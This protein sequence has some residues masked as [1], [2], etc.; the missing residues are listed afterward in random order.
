M[1]RL[2]KDFKVSHLLIAIN[3]ALFSIMFITDFTL[4][5]Y[6]LVLFGAK[7]NPLIEAG[8][9]YRLLTAAFVHADLQ[10]LLF[11]CFALYFIGPVVE[12]LFGKWRFLP[13]YLASAIMGT[14]MSYA[15]SDSLSV[16]ASGAIFGLL[17]SH[18]YLFLR[19]PSTY[20]KVYGKDFLIMIGLNLLLG[21]SV[22]NIDNFGHLGGLLGGLL[23]APL[24]GIEHEKFPRKIGLITLGV[25][26]VS[27]LFFLG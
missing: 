21:L 26:V 19:N 23:I 3:V 14:A 7:Y 9:F 22:S 5:N 6:T 12:S 20:L 17:G 16:G 11:N 24:T 4:S 25:Y 1:P 18:V 15:F 13:I 2:L 10:H 8:Q 27:I